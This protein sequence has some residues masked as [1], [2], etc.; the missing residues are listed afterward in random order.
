MAKEKINPEHAFEHYRDQGPSRTMK[1]TAEHFGVVTRTIENY[2]ARFDWPGRLA[3]EGTEN[4]YGRLVKTYAVDI[5]EGLLETLKGGEF[6]IK[7]ASDAVKLGEFMLKLI[8]KGVRP[9]ETS[10]LDTKLKEWGEA[11]GLADSA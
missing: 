5:L 3:S 10:S 6:P 1:R 7:N 2:S 11:F 4:P 9:Q 8:D